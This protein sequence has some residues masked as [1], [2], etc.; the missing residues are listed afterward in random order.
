MQSPLNLR[1]QSSA[2]IRLVLF[3]NTNFRSFSYQSEQMDGKGDAMKHAMM[4]SQREIS[5]DYEVVTRW[6]ASCLPSRKIMSGHGE[7]RESRKKSH[8][9]NP[10]NWFSA[11]T[12][13]P[14]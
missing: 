6:P 2:E 10:T 4:Q 13:D 12:S 1:S 9:A 14:P 8:P 11:R 3:Q 5:P 7:N